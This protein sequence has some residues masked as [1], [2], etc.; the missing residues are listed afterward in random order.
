MWGLLTIWHCYN[1]HPLN[2]GFYYTVFWAKQLKAVIV[3]VCTDVSPSSKYKHI[4]T[5]RQFSVDFTVCRL[6]SSESDSALKKFIEQT[7]KM[8]PEERATF[9]EKDEVRKHWEE[10][11][12]PSMGWWSGHTVDGHMS[13]GLHYVLFGRFFK[14]AFHKKELRICAQR[15]L[16][17]SFNQSGY[18]CKKQPHQYLVDQILNV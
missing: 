6:F 12:C 17:H 9:L 3:I 13:E 1:L 15:I 8:T 2:L 4:F 18:R 16:S 7:S 11:I 14:L 5:C 10:L